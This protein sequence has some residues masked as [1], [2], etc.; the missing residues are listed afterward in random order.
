MVSI[1]QDFFSRIQA[2]LTLR[3]HPQSNTSV[4]VYPR[5]EFG[6]IDPP[7]INDHGTFH[8]LFEGIGR[9]LLEFVPFSDHDTAVSALDAFFRAGSVGYFYRVLD[10]FILGIRDGYRIISYDIGVLGEEVVCYLCGWSIPH[11]ISAGLEGEPQD[12]DSLSLEV[13]E[14][15][16]YQ[17]DHMSCLLYIDLF[18]CLKN[19]RLDLP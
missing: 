14:Y 6:I 10:E 15:L 18:H 9:Q 1:F 19:G 3:F 12:G 4:G 2:I 17:A 13:P 5:A 7:A 8:E 11:V 16:T